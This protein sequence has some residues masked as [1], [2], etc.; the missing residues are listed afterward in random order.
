VRDRTLTVA[1][2]ARHLT[3]AQCHEH[4]MR[5]DMLIALHGARNRYTEAREFFEHELARCMRRREEAHH[6]RDTATSP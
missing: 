6:D 4:L 5:L 3:V 2:N 1:D